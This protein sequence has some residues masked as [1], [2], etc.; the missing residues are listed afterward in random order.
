MIQETTAS[1]FNTPAQVVT[2][3]VNCEGVMGAGLALEFALRHPDLEVAY[4][5]RCQAGEVRTG[6]PYLQSVTQAPYQAV[7]QFPTKRSW[8]FPSRLEWID[9]GLSYIARHYQNPQ[10]P[11]HSL[12]LPRLGCDRGGLDWSQVRTLIEQRL[13]SLSE[14]TLYLC[15]DTAPAE[16]AEAS[17]LNAYTA[18]HHAGELPPFLTSKV[19]AALKETAPPERFRY[20][21]NVPGVGRQSY[22]RLFQH[23]FH[24]DA[25]AQLPLPGLLSTS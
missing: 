7:L 16:G 8:R 18:D 25:M 23:Y 21:A 2:N 4:E 20:L 6:R 11:I 12:A 5:Q 17:M 14:L 19:R 15:D 10:R 24:Q 9:E 3:T 22:A 13:G 1:V